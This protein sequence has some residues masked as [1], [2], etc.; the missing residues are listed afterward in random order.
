MVSF[1]A[2]WSALA[3]HIR[4]LLSGAKHARSGSSPMM[5]FASS[6]VPVANLNYAALWG[7]ASEED[8]AHLMDYLV[9]LDAMVVVSEVSID[10]LRPKLKEA[11]LVLGGSCP[12]MTVELGAATPDGGQYR[13]EAVRDEEGLAVLTELLAAAYSLDPQHMSD[14]FGA[15]I[16]IEPDTTPFLAWRDD[17]ADSAVIATRVGTD[18]GIWAMGTQP[19]AQRQGAGRALLGAVMSGFAA[20]GASRCF[21][22]PSPAGRRLY[23]S[24][25]FVEVDQSEIWLKGFSTEFPETSYMSDGHNHRGGS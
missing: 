25:G 10:R 3:T 17:E 15:A 4:H 23:D 24:L 11:G 22:F 1:D 18:V 6:G 14:S 12:L 2:I 21:L 8:L 20:E 19:D 5:C 16:L 7:S 9:D 13:I